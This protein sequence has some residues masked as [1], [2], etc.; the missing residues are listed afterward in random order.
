V[1]TFPQN[2]P[3][4]SDHI[5][6]LLISTMKMETACSYKRLISTDNIKQCHS[7]EKQN[8]ELERG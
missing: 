5:L 8:L 2:L 4:S 6:A 1:P 3:A 7:P